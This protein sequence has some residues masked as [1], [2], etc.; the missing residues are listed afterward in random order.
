MVYLQSKLTSFAVLILILLLTNLTG[1]AAET[2]L[3]LITIDTIRPDRLS[4]YSA[5]YLQTPRI[6]ALAARGALFERAFAHDPITLPSHANILLGMTSLIHGVNENV[7]S[8]VSAEF[9]TLAETL[10]NRGYATGAFV[11]A[12]PLDSRFGLNR[13]FDIYD[14]HYPAVV[15]AGLDFAERKAE[16]TVAAA[17]AWLSQRRGKWFCWIH[18]W[19]PHAPYSPPEPYASQF[20]RDPY[21]GEVAYVDAQLGS[22][23]ETVEKKAGWGKRSSF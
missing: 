7:K 10:K 8:L 6:D 14:D 5:K 9:V 19:D 2:N 20:S 12:F 17:A 18:L 3:L 23:L 1:K 21:S 22:L 13:G 16:K 11:S 15:S 4:C